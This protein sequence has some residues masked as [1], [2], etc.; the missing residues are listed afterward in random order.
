MWPLE[1]P[2]CRTSGDKALEGRGAPKL[3]L[4]FKDQLV[5]AQERHVSA[6]RE[7]GKNNQGGSNYVIF[8][9]PSSPKCSAIL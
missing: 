8:K 4:V 7:P 9:V 6:R 2:A 5:Q 3:C 1:G